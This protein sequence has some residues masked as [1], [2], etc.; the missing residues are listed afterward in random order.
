LAL[1]QFVYDLEDGAEGIRIWGGDPYDSTCWEVGQLLFERWWFIFDR[2]IIEQSNR[3]RA[4][5]GA[6]NLRMITDSIG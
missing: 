3:W 5:R 6:S 2:E 4:L 1:L